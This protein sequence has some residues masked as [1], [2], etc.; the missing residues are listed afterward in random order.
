[1]GGQKSSLDSGEVSIM[2][3]D[4]CKE[5]TYIIFIEKSHKKLCDKCHDKKYKKLNAVRH[6]AK[7]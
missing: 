2:T 6:E 7:K 5:Q 4:K 3:C 1:M